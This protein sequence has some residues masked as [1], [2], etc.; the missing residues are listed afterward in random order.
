MDW[1]NIEIWL[2]GECNSRATIRVRLAAKNHTGQQTLYF[3]RYRIDLALKGLKI[4]GKR[5][6][7]GSIHDV[8]RALRDKVGLPMD[9][10]EYADGPLVGNTVTL[11]PTIRSLAYFPTSSIVLTYA[12]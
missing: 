11:L 7:Y 8:I 10:D 1:T 4:P 5:S 6:D 12:E 9:T 2:Q 3:N